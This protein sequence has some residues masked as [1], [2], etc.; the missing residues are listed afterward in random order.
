MRTADKA[1]ALALTPV[2]R[3]THSPES[4]ETRRGVTI[5]ARASAANPSSRTSWGSGLLHRVAPSQW[6]GGFPI[7]AADKT[8]ALTLTSVSR[9]TQW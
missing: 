4:N 7:L 9:E 5:I 8:A 6:R 1:A 2:S 3:E